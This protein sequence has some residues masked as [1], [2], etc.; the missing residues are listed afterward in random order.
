YRQRGDNRPEAL[1][2]DPVNRLVWKF[3]RR[4]LD[5]EAIRDAGL[6]VSGSLDATMGGRSV[7]INATPFPPRRTVY[8]VID[9]L[10]LDGVYRTFDFASPD[11]S[12]PRRLVTTVPQ[13]ALFLMNSPFVI[14][15]SRRLAARADLSDGTPEE[16]VG[17][18]YELLFGRA[19][20]HKERALGVEFLRRQELSG[21][22]LSPGAK[23][24]SPSEQPTPVGLTPWEEYAQVLLLTNEFVFV[25]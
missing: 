10:G 16:R 9:R 11:A 20:D 14:E 3:N 13:Q 2:R 24:D 23:S 5:F 8:G 12:S 7:A 18:L 19:P 1:A 6:T 4:R 17:R 22:S 21:P 15:Q 25:D